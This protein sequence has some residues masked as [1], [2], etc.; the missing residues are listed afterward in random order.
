MAE[1]HTVKIR[2]VQV[3]RLLLR[4][5][6]LVRDGKVQPFDL[7]CENAS[8]AAIALPGTAAPAGAEVL[9]GRG[10]VAG[11]GFIDVHVHGG[12]GHSFFSHDPARIRAYARWAP[13]V[14]VTSFLVST[15]GRDQEETGRRLSALAEAV[16]PMND[17]AEA[18]GFHLEGPFLNP[19]RR[20]AFDEAD[21]R[22]PSVNEYRRYAAA[23]GGLIR[24]VTVAP[25]LPGALDLVRAVVDSGA[26]AAMGHTDA[27][28]REAR[29]GFAAGITHVTHL[30]NAMRPIHQR[31][32]G[33]IVAALLE[34]ATSCELICDGAHVSPEVLR[35]AYQV[36]GADR[37]VVVTDNLHIAG[38]GSSHGK[39]GASEVSAS[40]GAAVRADGTIVGSVT[41]FDQHFR[42]AY[43][44]LGF[45]L[46][47]AFQVCS[48]NPARVAGAAA[49]KGRLE[50]GMDADIV[51]LDADLR[52]AA[53]V[54]R[55]RVVYRRPT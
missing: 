1:R 54:C 18:L 43:R 46:P 16:G 3:G 29:A 32:G 42:N 14:G 12:G 6:R 28:V 36:L 10:M 22:A 31:E 20:G 48:A 23:A 45:D 21:L 38:T 53:T 35:L 41:T 11:P 15:V 49:R 30:F 33:P 25:E 47:S 40:G 51:L 34:E 19:I 8:V 26:V 9:E 39:F 24:Q 27:T 44:F 17:G 37:T 4:N 55:G 2:G 50:P 13:S 52:V 7:L 5:I